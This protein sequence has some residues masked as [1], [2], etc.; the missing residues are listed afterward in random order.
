MK[1]HQILISLY[2]DYKHITSKYKP[3]KHGVNWFRLVATMT[4]IHIL[5]I[6]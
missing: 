3:I 6:S 5:I 2:S 4:F 1:Q